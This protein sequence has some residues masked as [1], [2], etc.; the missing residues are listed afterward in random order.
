VSGVPRNKGVPVKRKNIR[1]P[2]PLM[3]E[4]DGIVRENRLY[5]NRQQFVE[6]A[7]REKIEKVKGSA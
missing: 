6:S 1:I 7:I 3:D 5:M 4:V 2:K